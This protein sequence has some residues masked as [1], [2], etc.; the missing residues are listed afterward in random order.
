MN[1]L[2]QSKREVP[3]LTEIFDVA[4]PPA[5]A[6]PAQSPSIARPAAGTP[7]TEAAASRTQPPNPRSLPLDEIRNELLSGA[8]DLSERVVRQA[9][10]DVESLLMEQVSAQ[11][12]VQ[13]PA[14]VE[15]VLRAHLNAA[16]VSTAATS[17]M[18]VEAAGSSKSR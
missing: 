11:I 12:Q 8:L 6:A 3:V 9:F 10:S 14:L 7:P 15:R 13:L 5:P 1:E 4:G 17:V 2:P 16:G 18:D